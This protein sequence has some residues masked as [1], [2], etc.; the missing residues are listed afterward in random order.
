MCSPQ[1]FGFPKLYHYPMPL[2]PAPGVEDNDPR[3]VLFAT[4]VGIPAAI[5]AYDLITL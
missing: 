4:V 3:D 1:I 5:R 2:A